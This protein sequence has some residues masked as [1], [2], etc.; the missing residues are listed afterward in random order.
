MAS[1]ELARALGRVPSGIFV[2]TCRDDERDYAMLASWVQQ[3][4]FEPPSVS[5]A[6]ASGRPI[7]QL[8]A[9][10][11][12]F[13]LNVLGEE[14]QNLMRQFVRPAAEGQD[15]F[16]GC[17]IERT[18]GGV[19]VRVTSPSSNLPSARRTLRRAASTA[20]DADSA[21]SRYSP[22]WS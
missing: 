22:S 14:Q 5:V 8:L 21:A 15:P 7:G 16:D 4:S 3:A 19:S 13:V 18:A 11:R 1:D 12:P 17:P 2:L 6:I 20:A 10:S 9:D